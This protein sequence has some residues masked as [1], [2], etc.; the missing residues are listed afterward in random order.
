MS[1]EDREFEAAQ[2]VVRLAANVARAASNAPAGAN[3][4]AVASQ[5]IKSAIAA[6]TTANAQAPGRPRNQG[7]WIRR[8]NT[9]VIVGF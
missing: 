3:P 6:I 4:G 5:A 2:G 8:G 1:M 9:I 7:Q